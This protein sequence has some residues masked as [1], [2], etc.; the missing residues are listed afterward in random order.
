MANLQPED[1]V[2]ISM[3]VPGATH[4]CSNACSLLIMMLKSAVLLQFPWASRQLLH[5]VRMRVT[6]PRTGQPLDLHAPLPSDFTD[7]LDHVK[8]PCNFPDYLPAM[9]EK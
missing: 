5:A 9:P 2:T 1:H 6:H 3:A 8:L 4:N 7:A